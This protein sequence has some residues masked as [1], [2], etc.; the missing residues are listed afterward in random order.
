MRVAVLRPEPDASA[1]AARLTAA[2]H[3]P[4]VAPLLGVEPLTPAWPTGPFAALA[5]T[6][7]HALAAPRPGDGRLDHLR[8]FAV[9]QRTARAAEAA[10]FQR[11]ETAAGDAT[12]L[13][14]LI[15]DALPA[16][17]GVLYLAGR[18]RK[19]DLE[20]ALVGA[21]LL[22]STVETYAVAAVDK[23][24][25]QLAAAL[26]HGALDAVLHYS[27]RSARIFAELAEK[28]GCGPAAADVLHVC[29]S[30]DVARGL[31]GLAPAKV[32]VA[33]HPDEPSLLR[34]IAPVG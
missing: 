17:A 23:L 8:V 24:P 34:R 5:M 1:T 22:V 2:G 28:A 19:P 21:G 29:L 6:S 7:A 10:G 13:A 27:Q 30:A 18:D 11:I 26:C 12:A 9:G 32:R 20:R 31:A 3:E 14:R 25:G 33:A 16:G 4:L 15:A